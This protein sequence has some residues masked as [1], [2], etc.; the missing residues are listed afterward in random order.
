MATVT[1]YIY[2]HYDP[3]DAPKPAD[4]IDLE[5]SWEQEAPRPNRLQG[6]APQFVPSTMPYDDWSSSQ[7]FLNENSTRR[8]S[9][10]TLG[11]SLSGWYRSLTSSQVSTPS[12]S[13]SSLKKPHPESMTPS[14]RTPTVVNKNNWFIMN[15]IHSEPSSSTLTPSLAEILDRDPPPLPSQKKYTPPV[16]LEIGPSNKGF[17]MLQRAGWNEGEVLGPA[18]VRRKPLEHL[19]SSDDLFKTK[20]KGKAK[21]DQRSVVL[22]KEIREVKVEDLDDITELRQI[23]VIDLSLSSDDAPSESSFSTEDD[24]K[25]EEPSPPSRVKT[26]QS[27]DEMSGNPAYEPK[28]LLTPIATVLKS[29]RLGIGLKAKTVGPYKASQ[30][31]IT[32]NAAALAAHIKV[33]EESKKRRDLFGRGRRG[34]ERR[35]RKEQERRKAMIAYL[36]SS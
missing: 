4:S 19:L 7:T 3:K 16:W 34:L 28:A 31:R 23:D 33:A 2:S 15:A 20:N 13:V 29:D 1:H 14:A 30:K 8:E 35:H 25:D 24:N 5:E 9:I 11:T 36:K 12:V 21:V 17:R 26:S 10:N 32:H 27:H 6:P 18:V 22:R